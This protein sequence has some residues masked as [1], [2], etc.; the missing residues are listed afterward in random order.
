M[1]RSGSTVT[2]A[3]ATRVTDDLVAALGR[4]MPQ[5][6][7]AYGPPSRTALEEIVASPASVLFVARDAAQGGA[8]VGSLTLVLFRIPSGVR[9]WIEDVVV[10]AGSRNQGI[11]EALNRAALQRA[12][13]AGAKA[14][15]L[16][17]RATREAANR[18]YHRLGFARRETNLYRHALSGVL[19]E[20]R[21][22]ERRGR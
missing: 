13:A 22:R 2:I 17:S 11:G 8:I 5:L 3:E 20:E 12:A 21:R 14:V 19:D 18:L 7:P 9:A 4:L 10:D 15:D 6:S 1:S 16:T